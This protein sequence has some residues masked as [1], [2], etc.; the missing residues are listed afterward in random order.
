MISTLKWSGL[1][2]VCLLGKSLCDYIC[3]G[4]T[5]TDEGEM[6]QSHLLKNIGEFNNKSRPKTIAG[7]DKKRD[8]YENAYAL[9]E[10]RELIL[11]AFKSGIFPT[12]E[13]QA[14]GLKI[15]TPNHIIQRLPITPAKVK[16]NSTSENVLNEIR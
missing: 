8:T 14:K 1:D 15:L 4:K 7:K 9:Y 16:G 10:S 13:R 11:N 3:T 12:K 5:N 2:V 6:D